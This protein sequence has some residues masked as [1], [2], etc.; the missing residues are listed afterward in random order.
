[1]LDL[2][3]AFQTAASTAVEFSW[4]YL[5]LA[6][7]IGI[8]IFIFRFDLSDTYRERNKLLDLSAKL[9]VLPVAALGWYLVANEYYF[10]VALILTAVIF[11]LLY[12]LSF[13]DRFIYE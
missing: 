12:L 8:V 11:Y 1:M 3:H 10:L 2:K 9:I 13:L 6:I 5:L 7:G 4:P